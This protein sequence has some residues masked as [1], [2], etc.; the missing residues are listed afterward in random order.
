M[1]YNVINPT[2][3]LLAMVAVF[4]IMF[5][6]GITPM[7]FISVNLDKRMVSFFKPPIKYK[8]E[9]CGT[10]S[11][12]ECSKCGKKVCSR[13]KSGIIKPKCSLCLENKKKEKYQEVKNNR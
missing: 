11:Y 1:I 2:V 5:K 8:C 7:E 13:H 3:F 12:F 9:I 6:K 4:Y 10:L